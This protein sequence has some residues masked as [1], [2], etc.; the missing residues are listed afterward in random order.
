MR[1]RQHVL[2]E[3]LVSGHINKAGADVA[4]IQIG[5]ANIYSDAA[6]LLFRQTIRVDA[7][8]RAHQRRLAMI[9]MAGGADDD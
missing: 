4:K 1:A 8:Q 5:K 2:D 3:S 9:D 7:R 6:P